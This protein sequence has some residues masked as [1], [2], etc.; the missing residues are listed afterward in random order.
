MTK[1]YF[2]IIVPVYKVE[3]YLPTCVEHLMAQKFSGFEVILVDDGSPDRCPQLCDEYAGSE[4][5]VRVVH[6]PNGGSSSARNAGLAH[7][8]GEYVIFLDSDDYWEGEDCLDSLFSALPQSGPPADVVLFGCKDYNCKTGQ[9]SVVRDGYD[10]ALLASAGR[11]QALR[12]LFSSGLFP[13]AAWIVAVR[14]ELLLR[15]SITFQEG[16]KG[17][18]YDWLLNVFVHAEVFRAVNYPFYIYLKY[19]TDSITGKPDLSSIQGLLFTVDKWEKRMRQREFASIRD[20]VTAYLAYILATAFV[21]MS[22][23]GRDD[24]AQ[25]VRLVKP[26]S[27][28]L[29]R[30]TDRKSKMVSRMLRLLGSRI[31]IQLCGAYYKNRMNAREQ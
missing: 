26:Y 3:N 25:A 5:R 6:K 18:D 2:S 12:Y 31:T 9:M 20:G 8:E 29:R 15:H 24:R 11:D 10:L 13:G 4:E 27:H 22:R 21:T 1:I 19:R 30:G 7:A 14:R 23:M 28:I 16:I 17:E